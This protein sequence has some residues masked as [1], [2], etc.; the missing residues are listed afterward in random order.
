MCVL[1]I[2]SC[3]VHGQASK[4]CCGRNRG[5]TST[6]RV[7]YKRR[8][9]E[10]SESIMSKKHE[11]LAYVGRGTWCLQMFK[12]TASS[13]SM[14]NTSDWPING[15]TGRRCMTVVVGAGIWRNRCVHGV[16]EGHSFGTTLTLPSNLNTCEYHLSKSVHGY[17]CNAN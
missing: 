16:W 3:T 15:P 4:S 13:M 9:D 12:R 14:Y 2:A 1:S 17:D 6:C 11:T 10:P 5:S 8:W 7:S